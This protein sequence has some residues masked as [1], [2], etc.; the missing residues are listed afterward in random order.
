[1]E[2]KQKRRLRKWL[3]VVTIFLFVLFLA[4]FRSA[5]ARA[6]WV[7]RGDSSIYAGGDS[8]GDVGQGLGS[9]N[10]DDAAE[11]REMDEGSGF[12]VD[13]IN[14]IICWI[15]S[16]IGSTL[17]SLLDLIGA[18]LDRLIYGRLVAENTLFTFDLSAGNVYGIV[19]A[20]IFNIL[21]SVTVTGIIIVFA[22]RLV[23]GA[24]KRGELAKSGLKDA[25]G[26]LVLSLLLLVLMPNFLDLALYIRDVILYTIGTEGASA[27]FGT[28][29]ST[30]II[31]VLAAAANENIISGLVYIA[32]IL[33]NLYFVLGY[34]G[35]A[36]AMTTDFV[37][38]PLV[39]LKS[40]YDRQ[41]LSN[42]VWE[43]VACMCVPIVDAVLIMIPSFIGIYASSLSLGS[44][45]GVSIVQLIICYL[46]IPA[47]SAA[48][49]IL[50]LHTN[51]LENAGLSTAAV[52]GMAAAR[53]IG[54][55][56]GGEREAKKNAELDR[57]RANAEE[58]LAQLEEDSKE[59][60]ETSGGVPGGLG[61]VTPLSEVLGRKEGER[62]QDKAFGMSGEKEDESP[63][64]KEQ[65]YASALAAHINGAED[66]MTPE[67]LENLPH[68]LD[69]Q[70]KNMRRSRKLGADIA[71][72]EEKKSDLEGRRSALLND[73][74][75]G[76][77]RKND[78]LDS[79][80]Q[81]ISDT[82][83]Q[84]KSMKAQK[85]A[86]M[87]V[88][89]K[90]RAANEKKSRLETEYQDTLDNP[91]LGQ[92]ERD[93][94]LDAIHGKISDVDQ[95]IADLGRQKRLLKVAEEKEILKTEPST[96]RGELSGLR[97]AEK[98][99]GGQREALVRERSQLREKQ[100]NYAAG[101]EKYQAIGDEIRGIDKQIAAKE[102]LLGENKTR[103]VA[104]GGALKQQEQGLRDRQAYNLQE[105]VRAQ[106]DYALAR[107]QAEQIEKSLAD[108]EGDKAAPGS[109]IRR[110][111]LNRDL[112]A[113]RQ[114]MG[115]SRRRLG[116]ISSE[117]RRIAARL[118]EV[119]PEFG[120]YTPEDYKE[121]ENQ[122][123]SAKGRQALRRAHIQ[124]EIANEQFLMESAGNLEERQA[125]RTRIA[126]LKG[127]V[128]DCGVKSAQIDQAL[129][130][131]RQQSQ[132]QVQGSGGRASYVSGKGN[133]FTLPMDEEYA[134]RRKAVMERYAN[135]DNFER[136]EF[137]DISHE[138]RAQLYRER[139]M[140]TQRIV[141]RR[142]L[143]GFVGAAAGG[144][145]GIWL[146]T[147][148]VGIGIMAGRS[149]GAEAG[150][151]A[152]VRYTLKNSS[153]RPMDYQ[154][155]PL[156]VH[157]ASD[158]RD[159]TEAGQLRTLERVQAEL[160]GSLKG[161]L[162][163]RAVEKEFSSQDM[164]RGEIRTLFKRHGISPENYEQ[165]R[166]IL[167][168]ELKPITVRHVMDAE[169]RVVE[170]C[171]GKEYASLSD[172]VK[173]DIVHSIAQPNM[174]VF[175]D[176]C[177]T[178]YLGSRWQPHYKEYLDD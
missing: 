77:D 60:Y 69:E 42:W 157:I 61:T 132:G 175:D 96:L 79:L 172:T 2:K 4:S 59:A 91:E 68:L 169:R 97:E 156:D 40:S 99:L 109:A 110:K 141:S 23:T 170:T 90:L 120:T 121:A 26:F 112:N 168:S 87:S 45:V 92:K 66:E 158:L 167:L 72:L 12:F 41:V 11:D 177:E 104:I 10:E 178:I 7:D 148:G 150:E 47:R 56:I 65:S 153:T 53:G 37:L 3:N 111:N 145:L 13:L 131:L 86:L 52:M 5:E 130:G 83:G 171:A 43:M 54:K 1:M 154:G 146:G 126:S 51:P 16:T 71:D 48:R 151:G 115:E 70:A 127:D 173:Q 152:A 88:D 114:K 55:A 81:A 49:G 137:S 95:E 106:N 34:V 144:T 155:R 9:L 140:R 124:K 35:V 149:I 108:M 57:E 174:D 164:L 125:H 75:M 36:L 165:K 101:T 64:G 28:E 38:F 85:E 102:L 14:T 98:E 129:E 113:A 27:L 46:I 62:M 143:G 93:E 32:A 20:A 63:F 139:A 116:E 135:I 134:A 94:K 6:S 18:S 176:L 50:G 163:Q 8:D 123:K 17:F 29:S 82:E 76:E 89:E 147:P 21:R 22:A 133:G 25:F 44:A 122:L 159:N 117:D 33:L 166:P 136:P 80:D 78:M 74:T 30:S 142:R 103:Q 160:S 161:D 19:G 162:F 67:E 107:E 105:R 15:L 31:S 84:I 119:S 100:G 138:K 39:V 118:Q 58:D 128:A 24:W 73:N